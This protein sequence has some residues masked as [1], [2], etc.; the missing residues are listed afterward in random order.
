MFFEPRDHRISSL[1]RLL[2]LRLLSLPFHRFYSVLQENSRC[3]RSDSAR[4]GGDD[5][6]PLG[7]GFKLHV[8]DH[9]VFGLISSD[10]DHSR[11]G[12]D[13]LA[14]DRAGNPH[15]GDNNIRVCDVFRQLSLFAR[16]GMADRHR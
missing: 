14:L 7:C 13:P 3:N 11:T 12:F 2:S 16:T 8:A 5:P 6:C 15:R 10:V 1:P 9:P 4:H